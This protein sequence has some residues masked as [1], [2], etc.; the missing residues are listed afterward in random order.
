MHYQR[1]TNKVL[2]RQ[3]THSE[4]VGYHGQ[5]LSISS[6][7]FDHSTIGQHRHTDRG[8]WPHIIIHPHTVALWYS[9]YRNVVRRRFT[10]AILN[11][12][13]HTNC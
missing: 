7:H 2:V 13:S 9:L 5:A 11:K 3:V 8:E 10:L 6:T 4:G 1:Q 12:H